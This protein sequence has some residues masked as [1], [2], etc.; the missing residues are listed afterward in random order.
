MLTIV[1]VLE[2]LYHWFILCLY[3]QK[4]VVEEVETV[5]NVMRVVIWP[6]TVPTQKVKVKCSYRKDVSPLPGLGLHFVRQIIFSALFLL[7]LVLNLNA[8]MT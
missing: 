7:C 3:L 4:V 1:H 5:S 8:L 6:E 2:M